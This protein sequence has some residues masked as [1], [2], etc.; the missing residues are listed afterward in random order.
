[1]E[2]EEKRGLSFKVPFLHHTGI[3]AVVKYRRKISSEK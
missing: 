2:K 1:M 3:F